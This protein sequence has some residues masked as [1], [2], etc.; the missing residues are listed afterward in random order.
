MRIDIERDKSRVPTQCRG[1]CNR[2]LVLERGL[3]VT[4][5]SAHDTERVA[6][7]HRQQMSNNIDL[8]AHNRPRQRELVES[9]RTT[10]FEVR[11]RRVKGARLGRF[12]VALQIGQEKIMEQLVILA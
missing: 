12:A 7:M 3:R 11:Q 10:A 6:R 4:I 2:A 1:Q 9:G 8:A 5:R